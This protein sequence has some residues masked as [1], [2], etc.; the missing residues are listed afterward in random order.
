MC[1]DRIKLYWR[2]STQDYAYLP[3][4]D[5]FHQEFT[6]P[7]Q[8]VVHVVLYNQLLITSMLISVPMTPGNIANVPVLFRQLLLAANHE[9]V[10]LYFI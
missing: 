8:Y 4:F 10:S 5:R 9:T 7:I 3:P 1:Q 6:S 2:L